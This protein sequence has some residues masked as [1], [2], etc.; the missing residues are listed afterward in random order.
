MVKTEWNIEDIALALYDYMERQPAFDDYATT[1]F[2][3]EYN[4]ILFKIDEKLG[5]VME[6]EDAEELVT[7]VLE[8]GEYK[9][10]Q[11]FTKGFATGASMQNC[12]RNDV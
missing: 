10:R 7:L 3:V 11:Y 1:F 12:M 2:K 8:Y 4:D 6:Y 9:C 5:K